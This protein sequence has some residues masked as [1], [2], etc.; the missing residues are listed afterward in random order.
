[1]DNNNTLN[2]AILAGQIILENGGETYRTEETITKILENKVDI[3]DTFVTPTGIFVSIEK[4]N[5]TTASV[6]RIKSRTIDLNKIALVND[7]ARKLAVKDLNSIHMENCK[8][9]LLNIKNINKYPS[10]LRYFSAGIAA[11]FSGLI[12]GGHGY[13]F[14]P[15]FI[16]AVLLQVFISYMEK[17]NFSIFII[18]IFGGSFAAIFGLLFSYFGI[19]SL[20]MIIIGSIMTLLPGV[21]II[22]AVR[23]TISGDL[24]SG[25]SR[26]VEAMMV[27][28]GITIG[29]GVALNLWIVLGGIL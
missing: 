17:Y 24:L 2:L 21:A 14:L 12:L 15:I 7:V 18:D 16:T 6:K 26:G 11:A 20:D 28:I 9:E 8:K 27:L 1:M 25:I 29:V 23:D 22:N 10:I 4:D 5:K 13:D 19:G 3:V